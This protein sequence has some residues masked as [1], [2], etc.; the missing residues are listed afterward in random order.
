[1]ND[2][3]AVEWWLDIWITSVSISYHTFYLPTENLMT[4]L[5][6]VITSLL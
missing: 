6:F 3:V 4:N 2:Y 1:M 5:V